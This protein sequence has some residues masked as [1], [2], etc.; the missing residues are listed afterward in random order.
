MSA[1]VVLRLAEEERTRRVE[2]VAA[3]YRRTGATTPRRART[4]AALGVP[5]A[6]AIETLFAAGVL[7]AGADADRWDLDEAAGAAWRESTR[8]AARR[9]RRHGVVGVVIGVIAALAFIAWA[10]A[11]GG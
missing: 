1:A 9:G 5:H 8:H 2:G 4:A 7:P 11:R 6:D 10:Y 3:A